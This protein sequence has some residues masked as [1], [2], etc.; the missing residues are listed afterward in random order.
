M[1][2]R[3]AYAV[4]TAAPAQAA[5]PTS[6]AVA[7]ATDLGRPLADSGTVPLQ[8]MLALPNTECRSPPMAAKLPYMVSPGLIPKI[9][10][11]IQNARKP[12]R[13]TQDYLETKLAHSGGSARA[14]IP[15]LKRMGF[16]GSDGVPLQLY[17]QFRNPETQAA[18][19]AQ[20]LRAAYHELFD[21]NE[22]V[23]EMSRDRLTGLVV[24]VTGG[25]KE[26][27][28]TRRIVG[29]FSALKDLADFDASLTGDALAADQ[30]PVTPRPLPNGLPEPPFVATD[31]IKLGVSYTINLNLPETSDPEVF[32]AIFR[33]L[34][35]HLLRN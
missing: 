30:P 29:T 15:L 17:D 28:V 9:L 18:A 26:D 19:V 27:S 20:G 23:Y 32:N 10:E 6:G 8:C 16:I 14:M 12:E 21:R 34:K 7:D 31:D 24:E 2:P 4:V 35:E 5:R 25:T 13:F 3:G 22:Y 33:S 1:T 11:K